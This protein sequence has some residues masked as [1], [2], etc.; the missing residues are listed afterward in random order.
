[1]TPAVP[2]KIN[3]KHSQSFDKLATSTRTPNR[4]D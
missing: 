4:Y 3:N 2:R 1:M